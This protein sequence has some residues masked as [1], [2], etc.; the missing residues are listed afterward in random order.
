MTSF[1]NLNNNN[2][3]SSVLGI[4]NDE[5]YISNYNNKICQVYA[6]FDGHG[7]KNLSRDLANGIDSIPSFCQF[8]CNKFEEF[9][10]SITVEEYIKTLFLEYDIILKNHHTGVIGS[11]A[12]IC[13]TFQDN[14]Y[15]A[16]VGD[17]SALII[18]D[19]NL[20]YESKNHNI[21]EDILEKNRLADANV[22]VSSAPDF[23]IKNNDEIQ[24]IDG[25]YH[26]FKYFY[27]QDSLAMTR[28]FGHFDVKSYKKLDDKDKLSSSSPLLVEPTIFKIPQE[29][30]LQ[31]VMASDGLWDVIIPDKK[32]EEINFLIKQAN[33]SG[34]NIAEN[35]TKFAENRW[36][37]EWIVISKDNTIYKTKMTHQKQWDDISCIYLKF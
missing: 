36:K 15:I 21:S 34:E 22:E 1:L 12:T 17:S 3:M 10:N 37:K 29:E 18:K 35:I 24:I 27:L 16:H 13:L 11:T 28:A 30:G 9:D 31:V 8:I 2:F 14:I 25:F 23:I 6:V 26:N 20:I 32:L 4:C 19:D 5:D 7:G 33:D